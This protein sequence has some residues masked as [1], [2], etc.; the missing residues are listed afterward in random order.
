MKAAEEEAAEM[1]AA[2]LVKG[3]AMWEAQEKA[4]PLEAAHFELMKAQL[5][6]QDVAQRRN[7]ECY[8]R[9]N[10]GW[11]PKELDLDTTLA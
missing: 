11:D 6:S 1:K 7:Q 9:G 4:A 10:Q 5:K 2:V 3:M 8:D